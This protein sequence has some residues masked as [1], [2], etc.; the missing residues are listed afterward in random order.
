VTEEVKSRFHGDPGENF[1]PMREAMK[2]L[3]V[4]RPSVWQRVTHGKLDAVHVRRGKQKGLQIKE[5]VRQ[6]ELFD[7]RS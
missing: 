2:A 5:V 6:G 7:R 3:A 4:S 1:L